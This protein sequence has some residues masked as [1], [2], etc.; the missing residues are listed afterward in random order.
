MVVGVS[1]NYPDGE[2]AYVPE[3]SM[4]LV[5]RTTGLAGGK[6]PDKAEPD[7]RGFVRIR[8]TVALCTQT[9][10]VQNIGGQYVGLSPNNLDEKT[11]FQFCR[12]PQNE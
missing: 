4:Q 2:G 5:T 12:S 6:G 3:A 10:V 1:D 9:N 8:T 11:V 7:S